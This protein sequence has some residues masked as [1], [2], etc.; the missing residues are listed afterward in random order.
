MK[1]LL[2]LLIIGVMVIGMFAGCNPQTGTGELEPVTLKWFMPGIEMEGTKDVIEAFNAKL[3]ELLPNTTVEF[4]FTG[5]PWEYGDPW[6]MALSGNQQMDIAWAGWC[7]NYLGDVQDGSI[8]DITDLVEQYAPNLKAEMALWSDS[9]ASCTY[10]GKL[11]GIPSI[12]PNAGTN[13]VMR[14]DNEIIAPY[15]DFEALRAELDKSPKLTKTIL[16]MVDDAFDAA[17]ADGKLAVG[18]ETWNAYFGEINR[19]TGYVPILDAAYGIYMDPETNQVMHVWEIPEIKLA[20]HHKAE[21][22]E[23]GWITEQMILGQMPSTASS[24]YGLS[25]NYNNNWYN[26]DKNGMKPSTEN[27]REW[28]AMLVEREKDAYQLTSSFGSASTYMVIPYTAKNPE[29]AIMLLDLLHGEVGTPGNDLMNLLCYGFEKGSAEAEQYGWYNYQAKEV[30]GQLV[31]DTSVRDGAE[32]KHELTNWV[33]GN[34]YKIMSPGDAMTSTGNKEYCEYYWKEV[35][36]NLKKCDVSGMA[37]DTAAFQ[38]EL[39]SMMLVYKEY[40]GQLDAGCGGTDKVES[41][42]NEALTKLKAAGWDTIKANLESQ[43]AAYKAGK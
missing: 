42:M 37:V 41:L 30:D 11:Y 24:F 14:F 35:Y 23:K 1:R 5:Q 15:I 8:M 12:Q 28:T 36:P 43:I 6:N 34:T 25:S 4:E 26:A 32:A 9:Y 3:A 13:T 7:T 21:W 33:M 39:N 29:R 27:G 17:I 20:A 10:E 40:S 2:S 16:D 38:D 22:F 31:V 18:S 19:P